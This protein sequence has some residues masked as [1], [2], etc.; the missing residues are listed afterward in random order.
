MSALPLKADMSG[1]ENVSQRPLAHMS[2]VGRLRLY[3]PGMNELFF[4]GLSA[5]L[6]QAGLAGTSETEIV[7]GFWPLF[8]RLN[9]PFTRG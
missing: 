5:W 4:A 3:S 7:S 2:P 6:T 8:K 9:K 1:R